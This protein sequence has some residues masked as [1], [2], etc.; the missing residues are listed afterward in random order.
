M[1][2]PLSVT[3]SVVALVGA[4]ATASNF[5]LAT[6]KSM[7][8]APDEIVWLSN[9]ISNVRVVLEEIQTK[10]PELKAAFDGPEQSYITEYAR[11]YYQKLVNQLGVVQR[12]HAELRDF[13]NAFDGT[14]T[15]TLDRIHFTRKKGQATRLQKKMKKSIKRTF[16]K[17]K[18][19]VL[20]NK[21][22]LITS[23]TLGLPCIASNLQFVKQL[24]AQ[25]C[26]IDNALG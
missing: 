17:R 1:T 24:R 12:H 19:T 7:R 20:E 25:H 21:Q 16:A 9:E 22:L 5:V 2:D 6:I 11:S 4:F 26:I 10:I 18:P 15:A 3:A 14:G 8:N 13:M 23:G